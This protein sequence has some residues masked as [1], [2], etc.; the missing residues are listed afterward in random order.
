MKVSTNIYLKVL[1]Q[2][3]W[4]NW[5][6]P[7]EDGVSEAILWKFQKYNFVLSGFK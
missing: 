4:E 2:L 3:P 5:W 7:Q 6:Q 1:T